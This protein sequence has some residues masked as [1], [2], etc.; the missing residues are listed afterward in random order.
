MKENVRKKLKHILKDRRGFSF[1]LV[2]AVALALV[3]ILCGISEYLRLCIIASG[4]RDAVQSAV[5]ATVTDN[6]S[7]V[8]HG[9]REGYSGGYRPSGSSWVGSVSTGDIY[10]RLDRNLG[11]TN[12][13]GAHVKEAGGAEEFKISGLSVTIQNAPLAP[14]NPANSPVFMADA[15]IQLEVPVSFGGKTLPPMHA[16][17]K[18]RAKYMP[19]F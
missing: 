11:L 17:L 9:I 10:G 16:K 6:Y 12:E 1:P 8:Y 3:L 7:N 13:S 2:V 15:T 14:S 4:V 19:V 5:V 18:V